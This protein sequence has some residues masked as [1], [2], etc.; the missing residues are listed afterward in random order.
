MQMIEKKI[1]EKY[2]KDKTKT[3]FFIDKECNWFFEGSLIKREAMIKLF[4]RYL[5]IDNDGAYHIVTPYEEVR[6]DVYDVPFKVTKLFFSGKGMGQFVNITTNVGDVI[7]IGKEHPIV[8]KVNP[9]NNGLK[10]YIIVRDKLEAIFPRSLTFELINHCEYKL[11]E[12]KKKFG[13]WSNGIFFNI[14]A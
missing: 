9:A 10:P 2:L 5:Q 3:K 4:S 1:V 12:N 6:V 11:E 8:Y 13:L 14:E 7:E